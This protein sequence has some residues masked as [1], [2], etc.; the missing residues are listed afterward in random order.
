MYLLKKLKN[1]YI[2]LRTF[3]NKKRIYKKITYWSV[4]TCYIF[5]GE[6]FKCETFDVN[7]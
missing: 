4:K 7:Y 5:E 3:L 1:F 2:V 6:L